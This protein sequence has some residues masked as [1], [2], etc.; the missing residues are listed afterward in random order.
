MIA[1]PLSAT[2]LLSAY[3]KWGVRYV[4]VRS[5]QTHNRNHK[6]P[7]GPVNGVMIHHTASSGDAGS[8]SL[9]YDGRSD[10]PGPL[11]HAVGTNDGRMHLVGHGRA[12]HAGNGDPD[13]LRAVIN[14]TALPSPNQ[15]TTD[16]N[17]NFY[18]L[19]IV[20]AGNNVDTYPE[21]QYLAAVLWAAS[22]CDAHGWNENS[23]IGHKEWTNQKIDP[24]GPVENRG[25]F[26]MNTFRADVRAVLANGP[27]GVNDV[28]LSLDD[29]KKIAK[30][31]GAFG[32]SAKMRAGNPENTEW[33]LESILSFLG[34]AVINIQAQLDGLHSQVNELEVSVGDPEAYAQ[35]IA[36]KLEAVKLRFETGEGV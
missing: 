14:E 23:V 16:G 36:D 24:R 22:I 13:V 5:W 6:G 4:G 19:E 30:S 25:A 33:K 8:V 20:N 7:W 9:C 11:C 1:T 3:K 29:V 28:A 12:N 27:D 21:V 15:S 34:D 2:A 26:N 10:L 32:V 17:D 35:A 18:G 31:D